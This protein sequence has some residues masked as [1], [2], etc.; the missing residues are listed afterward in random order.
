MFLRQKTTPARTD[1][2]SPETQKPKKHTQKKTLKTAQKRT[3]TRKT[4][5]KHN[6][7][8]PPI[9]Y[10][11][12]KLNNNITMIKLIVSNTSP[13]TADQTAKLKAELKKFAKNLN[14][15]TP[16]DQR[17]CTSRNAHKRG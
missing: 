16:T 3:K 8:K 12:P 4:P 13:A 5:R 15:I 2:N 14:L 11:N 1:K 10:S 6:S 17:L 7:T 9:Y